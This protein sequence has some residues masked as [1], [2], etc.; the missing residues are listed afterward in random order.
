MCLS[1][2]IEKLHETRRCA[3]S[4][5][6]AG[7]AIHAIHNAIAVDIRVVTVKQPVAIDIVVLAI[8]QAVAV[9]IEVLPIRRAVVIGILCWIGNATCP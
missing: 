3:G 8:E 1:W 9:N 7:R 5:Q 2:I 6:A 4:K